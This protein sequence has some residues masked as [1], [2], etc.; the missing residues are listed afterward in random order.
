M[1][2]V[3]CTYIY[4]SNYDIKC[5]RNRCDTKSVQWARLSKHICLHIKQ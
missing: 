2:E 5:N 4:A 1:H 3:I